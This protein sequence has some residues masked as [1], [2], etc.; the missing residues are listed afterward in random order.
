MQFWEVNTNW[1]FSVFSG[2]QNC[3][4]VLVGTP[5]L[6]CPEPDQSDSHDQKP[7]LWSVLILCFHKRWCI[8][9]SF[10]P[11]VYLFVCLSVYAFIHPP[12][13]PSASPHIYPP[14]YPSM[15][16]QPFV[17]LW[18]LFSFL[19]F[20]TVSRTSWTGWGRVSPSQGRYLHTGQHKY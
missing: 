16:L 3:I 11:S 1:K 4:A 7:F 14:I 17:G 10:F 20:Y 2:N 13:R 9:L 19:I 5:S 12:A 15:A 6:T 18:P 8:P